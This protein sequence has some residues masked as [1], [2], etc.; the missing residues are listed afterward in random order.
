MPTGRETPQGQCSLTPARVHV[1]HV[2]AHTRTHTHTHT[3][4]LCWKRVTGLG[5]PW[6]VM[7]V[8]TQT[9]T[10]THTHTHTHTQT[11]THAR[12]HTLCCKQVMGLGIPWEVCLGGSDCSVEVKATS[13]WTI[14]TALSLGLHPAHPLGC[15]ST[16]ARPD[17]RG[18]LADPPPLLSS[19]PE[20]PPPP[21]SEG[22]PTYPRTA[23]AP[24]LYKDRKSFIPVGLSKFCC[25]VAKLCL[26]LLRPH[27]LLSMRFSK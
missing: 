10:H 12:T 6:H 16:T 15:W 23:Q 7:H 9:R 5:I 19:G 17:S 25:L 22:P 14:C 26:T 2:C 3:H 27:A 20:Y 21:D 24:H 1:R 11:R 8:C 4:P 13:A 18:T